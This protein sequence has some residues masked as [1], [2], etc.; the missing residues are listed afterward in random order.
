MRSFTPP[1][2]IQLA[3]LLIGCP[4]LFPISSQAEGSNATSGS[5]LQPGEWELV[6]ADEFNG[7]SD[8]WKDHWVADASSHTHILSSR[9][10]ENVVQSNGSLRL[11][12]KKEWR[13]GQEWTS[14]SVGAKDLRFQYGYYECRYKYA[15]ASGVNNSFWLIT[16]P[17]EIPA[18]LAGTPQGTHYELDINEGHYPNQ[19]TCNIHKWTPPHTSSGKLLQLGAK[20]FFNFPLEIPITTDGIRLQLSDTS[21]VSVIELRALAPSKGGYPELLDANEETAPVDPAVNLLKGGKVEASSS[22]SP[23]FGPDHLL[24]A[25]LSNDSRWVVDGIKGS[26]PNELTIILPKPVTIG[27]LQML[28]G[29]KA[30]NEWKQCAA[31]FRFQYRKNGEW[32]DLA[33]TDKAAAFTDLSSDFHVYGLEWTPEELVFYHDG[34]EWRREKNLFCHFPSALLMSSAIITWAGPLSDRINGTAQEI[35]WVRVWKRKGDSHPVIHPKPPLQPTPTPSPK[36]S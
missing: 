18:N 10:P 25:R 15:A 28:S 26:K 5:L 8:A 21:H 11:L 17:R 1:I 14:G 4:L 36:S 33:G 20:P 27:C 16:N 3:F 30:E 12:N 22:L 2:F 6:F 19:A 32:I 7:N 34:K 35:D 9:W 29:Y 23:E 24:D 13:G 31:T